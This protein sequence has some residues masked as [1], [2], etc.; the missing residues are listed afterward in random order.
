MYGK[1]EQRDDYQ[2]VPRPVAAMARDLPDGHHIPP[3]EHRRAQLIYGTTGAITV[4]TD[5]GAWVVPAT[6]GVWVPAGL[7]H[8]MTCAGAVAIPDLRRESRPSGR[9]GMR[10]LARRRGAPEFS[11]LSVAPAMLTGLTQKGGGLD[12]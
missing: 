5:H 9:A 12:D 1:S 6:R 3:H 2:D 11:A 7:T 4:V 10:S 8:A